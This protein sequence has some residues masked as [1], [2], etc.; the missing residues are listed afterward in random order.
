MTRVHPL[1]CVAVLLFFSFASSC[2]SCSGG[3]GDDT[4]QTE[5]NVVPAQLE[6]G[7]VFE[8]DALPFANY[9][10]E[11]FALMLDE[12]SMIR[13]FGAEEVCEEGSDPCQLL[14]VADAWR[15][16]IFRALE[17]GHSEGF[18]LLTLLM[19]TGAVD[20][21]EFGADNPGLLR[22]SGNRLLQQ[23][24]SYWAATQ[25]VP[26]ATASDVRKTASEVMP[27][28]TEI[29]SP[30]A[31]EHYRLAIVRRT[32]RGFQD[33]HALVPFG[34]YKGEGDLY[35][36][37]VYD[38]NFP[39]REQRMQIDPVANTWRYEVTTVLDTK[40][41]YEGDANN[42][43]YFSRI[44]DRQGVLPSPFS[45]QNDTLTI[46]ADPTA[47]FVVIDEDGNRA[48]I[49]QGVVT[50]V[51]G[52]RVE[53]VFS[54][55]P[56]CGE[57]YPITNFR[58]RNFT[59]RRE[60][61][62]NV[63]NYS[64]SEKEGENGETVKSYGNS[65]SSYGGGSKTYTSVET[66]TDSDMTD[67]DDK[68]TFKSNGDVSYTSTS[69]KGVKVNRS[70]ASGTVSVNFDQ[71]VDGDVTVKI[72][73]QA[74]GTVDVTVEGLPEGT[75]VEVTFNRPGQESKSVTFKSTDETSTTSVDTLIRNGQESGAIDVQGGSDVFGGACTN[76]KFDGGFETGLDC[77]G[78]CAPCKDSFGC[79]QDSDCLNDRCEKQVIYSSGRCIAL[80]TSY[81]CEDSNDLD[82]CVQKAC[83][84]NGCDKD[85]IC[86]NLP[87]GGFCDVFY[88]ECQSDANCSSGACSDRMPVYAETGVCKAEICS[89]GVKNNDE[90]ATDCGGTTC[91]PCKADIGD[92]AP[93]C[94]VD[95]DCDSGL[96]AAGKCR[97]R[98]KIVLEPSGY[99]ATAPGGSIVNYM[100]DGQMYSKRLER[101]NSSSGISYWD[102]VELGSGWNYQL[103]W[104]Q[105][106]SYDDM[107][108]SPP[109]DSKVLRP[110]YVQREPV[111]CDSL[112]KAIQARITYEP[113]LKPIPFPEYYQSLAPYGEMEVHYGFENSEHVATRYLIG[114]GFYNIDYDK[115]WSAAITR[116]PTLV[117]EV[118][119]PKQATYGADAIG[120]Y[121]C[122]ITSGAT[123][124]ISNGDEFIDVYCGWEVTT[125]SDG[126]KN[127]QETD[128]DCGGQ[129]C[130]GTC[131]SGKA[132]KTG[133][134]CASNTC[135]NKVCS[136]PNGTCDDMMKNQDETDVDC[137]GATCR[138]MQRCTSGQGCLLDS[139]C[140]TSF[141]QN[142]VC[143]MPSC[144]D[145]VKNQGERNIDCGGPCD[146]CDVG[147]YCVLNQDCASGTCT[148]NAC[149]APSCTDG[150]KN[151]DETDV[152]CGGT[153]CLGCGSG[154]GCNLNTDCDVGLDCTG[155]VCGESCVDGIK[156]QDETDV[157]CGGSCGPCGLNKACS[158][159][160]ECVSDNCFCGPNS[161]SC[162]GGIGFC[163]AGKSIIDQPVTDGSSVSATFT[164]PAS[165]PT[166]YIQAWGAAGGNE[167]LGMN[168]VGQPGGAGGFVSGNL[169]VAE[170]DV[171]TVWLGQG[172]GTDI[173][174][175][176][177]GSLYGTPAFGGNGDDDLFMGGGGE[178]GG[179]TSVQI[180]GTN[181]YAFTIPGG[182]GS[183]PFIQGEAATEFGGG[184][185]MGNGGQ[186]G[187]GFSQEPGGGAGEP[188]GTVGQA[189]AYGTLPTGLSITDGFDFEPGGTMNSDY[190]RCLGANMGDPSA[191]MGD[192]LGFLGIGG[193]G[194]V[195]IRCTAP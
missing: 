134:D 111:Q 60:I 11:Q 99:G 41:V 96:C 193:D 117:A 106:C 170:N 62:V 176:A 158:T 46:L 138:F 172:G 84:A 195:V 72:E 86:A 30:E 168:T 65:T 56:G 16:G 126:V 147:A 35:W 135:Y 80:G 7:F 43:L 15:K 5:K 103:L 183:S 116:Q 171:V 180:T 120:V 36:L 148:N 94:A 139:D 125:C 32:S 142:N 50:E 165:C 146:G 45:E 64:M 166:I 188:G 174:D 66:S 110:N 155:G 1:G 100:L 9:G 149:T 90:T 75:E 17:E 154:L 143:A 31:K 3:D 48:G 44:E 163:G 55:C 6:S 81:R 192:S 28:L 179:L 87:E 153:T 23:E 184:G 150:I 22:I 61:E 101:I 133:A 124:Q 190:T 123:G 69:S 177:A 95:S 194:C 49:E 77:G 52:Q 136:E 105:G 25:F 175:Q 83:G 63:K 34:F 159:D 164:V 14:P 67:A 160:A 54:K 131:E 38:S 33:S 141:C 128:I 181:T 27:F 145:G 129:Y 144:S 178:G 37:R 13:M 89:D 4:G 59:A 58:Y 122:Q 161:G 47:S 51:E 53:P 186:N 107:A 191:G 152:D 10:T 112:Y 57:D 40:L 98:V 130:G 173:F 119:A 85:V 39:G 18:S 109:D 91:G 26:A 8:R 157:D 167:N 169:N 127:Q 114:S 71:D 137:G 29:L 104:V 108:K 189:G 21:T 115:D 97:P 118:P 68:I 24:I 132:C 92:D 88:T 185:F 73:R 19:H 20:V 151:Q 82:S 121:D 93:A 79:K 2:S 76:G 74:D 182:G 102:Q 162:T 187:S 78:S 12:Q 42:P 156:N 113:G 140:T 70:D